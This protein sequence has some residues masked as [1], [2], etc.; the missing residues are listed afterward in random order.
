[1]N[2]EKRKTLIM[3]ATNILLNEDIAII[4]LYWTFRGMFMNNKIKNFHVPVGLTDQLKAE[5]LWCDP[6]C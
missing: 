2:Q 4:N 3:E 5:H 6:S 1:M